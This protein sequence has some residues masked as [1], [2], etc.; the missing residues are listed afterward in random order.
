MEYA[1]VFR[2]AYLLAGAYLLGSIS[3]GL[4]LGRLRRGIDL[5][6]VGSGGTGATNVLRTMGPRMA[7]VVLF[8][9]MAKGVTAVALAKLLA[10][11]IPMIVALAG[12]LVIVGHIWPVFSRFHGGRGI[13]TA[14][15]ALVMISLPTVMMATVAFIPAV[16]ITRYVSLGSLLA[17]AT[18]MIMIPV[19]S[20]AG[21]VPWEYTVFSTVGGPMILWRH[22]ENIKRL[23]NG[24]ERRMSFRRGQPSGNK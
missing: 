14:V 7:A 11:D 24:T 17:V 8:A 10:D 12:I 16:A 2:G 5:R 1:L 23:L 18:S 3:W 22:R 13:A 15:G 9:D 21:E 6:Q 4:I 19:L 20:A